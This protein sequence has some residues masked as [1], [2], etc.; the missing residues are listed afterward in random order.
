MV[1]RYLKY[2]WDT[3]RGRTTSHYTTK[4]FNVKKM[5][6]TIKVFKS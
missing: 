2:E 3:Y 6:V 1:I 5:Q 4:L